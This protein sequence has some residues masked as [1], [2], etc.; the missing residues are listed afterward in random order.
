MTNDERLTRIESFLNLKFGYTTEPTQPIESGDVE[1]KDIREI[2]T[3]GTYKLKPG[4][5]TIYESYIL[6]SGT[7]VDVTGSTFIYSGKDWSSV[8]DLYDTKDVTI[9][10]GSFKVGKNNQISIVNGSKNITLKNQTLLSDSGWAYRVAGGENV[11]L[12]GLKATTWYAYCVYADGNVK[13]LTIKNWYVEGGSTNESLIRI[14]GAIGLTIKDCHLFA[15]LNKSG[16]QKNVAMRLHEGE[17]FLIE[18][19][20]VRGHFGMGPMGGGD[21][22]QNWGT[23]QFIGSDG[24]WY[25]PKELADMTKTLEQRAKT[26]ALR[27]IKVRVKNVRIIEG[28]ATCNAG[29]IDAQWDGG[30]I[31]NTTPQANPTWPKV[32]NAFYSMGKSYPDGNPPYGVLLKGDIV[33]PR[34]DFTIK[35]VKFNVNEIDPDGVAKIGTGCTLNGVAV[36]ASVS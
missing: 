29:L 5:F 20:E 34:A 7:T 13:N 4:T 1:V 28:D 18:N 16:A 22:G 10:G 24:K 31:T 35:N 19:C 11:T 33:R 32:N 36:A 2:K 25:V 6:P 27:T 23:I 8:F 12:D 21:G 9:T 26:L 15:D 3:S 30:S 14:C 17:N